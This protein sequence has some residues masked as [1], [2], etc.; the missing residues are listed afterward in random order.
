MK[1]KIK[2]LVIGGTGFIGYHILKKA[3]KKNWSAYSF[4]TKS[5]K[6]LRK[7]STVKYFLGD[8]SKKKTLNKINNYYD[9]IINAGGYVDHS[10]K[11]KVIETHFK[12]CKNLSKIF[13]KKKPKLFIQVGSSIEY[14]KQTSPQK[15]HHKCLPKSAYGKA[16]Y[17]ATKFLFNL[18]KKKNFPVTIIRPYQVYG[19][20]QDINRLIPTVI[21][22]CLKNKSFP[23]SHG[24][25]KRDFIFIDDLV[26]FIFKCF[27]NKKAKGKIFNLG[28][29]KPLK[30]KKIIQNIQKKINKGK[31][32]FGVIKLR[33][34]EML[35][36]FPSIKLAKTLLN[37]KPNVSFSQGLDKTISYYKH[38][39]K[40]F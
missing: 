15:E 27:L 11:K 13:L 40:K 36:T 5:P 2:I 14:G 21:N 39:F 37:W 28:S 17:M 12:A 25:Q 29:S 31:P 32:Q 4:S 18:F 24:N 6:K 30:V 7:L 22:S 16:K 9:F 38:N 3:L 35:E 8:I 1:N 26:A 10:N 23:C 34:E 33:K 20:S 19:P